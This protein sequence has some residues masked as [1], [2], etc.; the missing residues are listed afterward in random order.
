[1]S[2]AGLAEIRDMFKMINEK[3]TSIEE[4]FE[5]CKTELKTIKK[6]NEELKI[7]IAEQGERLENLEKETRKRNIVIKGLED[8]AVESTGDLQMKI[9]ELIARIGVSLNGSLDT[10]ETFRL[11]K[12]REGKIRPILVKLQSFD[13]KIEI[14]KKAKKLKDSNIWIDDDVTKTVQDIRRRL[15]PHLKVARQNGKKAFLKYDQ[16]II[17][18]A[19]YGIKHFNQVDQEEIK[20]KNRTAAE[21]S[22]EEGF[23]TKSQTKKIY[24]PS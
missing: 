15:V 6:E 14:Y 4:K 22:P 8:T 7:T 10:N 13:K 24:R 18:G 23:K 12:F 9:E 5:D 19:K 17:E 1:M 2:A 16:L 3:L 21:R 20:F 11:G